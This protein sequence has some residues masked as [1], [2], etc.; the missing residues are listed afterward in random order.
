MRTEPVWAAAFANLVLAEAVGPNTLVGGAL[1]IAA[2]I[3]SAISPD[4]LRKV[5]VCVRERGTASVRACVRAC[6][7]AYVTEREIEWESCFVCVWRERE[8]EGGR[9][10]QRESCALY[11]R[12]E[13]FVSVCMV[14]FCTKEALAHVRICDW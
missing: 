4:K 8:R 7:R 1:I 5:C 12:E 6:V 10:R 9:E 3:S 14:C 13:C 11:G 2:C